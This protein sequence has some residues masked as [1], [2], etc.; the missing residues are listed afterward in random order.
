MRTF[1]STVK[2]VYS[3]VPPGSVVSFVAWNAPSLP[4]PPPGNAGTLPGIVPMAPTSVPID[5]NV[6]AGPGAA[7]GSCVTTPCCGAAPAAIVAFAVSIEQL[8]RTRA[9]ATRSAAPAMARRGAA[10]GRCMRR[11]PDDATP[12]RTVRRPG[13]AAARRDRT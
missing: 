11:P 4:E 10:D 5:G 13:I 6:G 7:H 1:T 12:M 8:A 2:D 3:Y 9:A